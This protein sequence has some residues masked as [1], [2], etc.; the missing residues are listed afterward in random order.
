MLAVVLA[1]TPALESSLGTLEVCYIVATLV[2]VVGL[3]VEV[4]PPNRRISESLAPEHRP[5][6]IGAALIILGILAELV[7]DSRIDAIDAELRSR[8][9]RTIRTDL[10]QTKQSL[11]R[12]TGSVAADPKAPT[13]Q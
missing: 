1:A 2:I 3:V 4:I 8:E 7:I 13:K 5:A 6:L 9:I 11:D 10:D 12:L